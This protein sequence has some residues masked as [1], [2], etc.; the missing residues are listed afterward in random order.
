M[1]VLINRAL[2]D[3]PRYRYGDAHCAADPAVDP[4]LGAPES[5]AAGSRNAACIYDAIRTLQFRYQMLKEL[6]HDH[7][8]G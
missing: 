5:S 6:D 7:G 2:A 4:A 8:D 1:A 3:G